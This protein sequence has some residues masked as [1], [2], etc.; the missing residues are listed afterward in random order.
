MICFG[1]VEE[2][3]LC[4]L[5]KNS[6]SQSPTN[7][8]NCSYQVKVTTI[9]KAVLCWMSSDCEGRWSTRNSLLCSNLFDMI[10]ALWHCSLSCWR[11]RWVHK[12]M[13]MVSL[14]APDGSVVWALALL[15]HARKTEVFVFFFLQNLFIQKNRV[16]FFLFSMQYT[17]LCRHSDM[18]WNSGKAAAAEPL[19][20]RKYPP[21]VGQILASFK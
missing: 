13:D 20:L 19:R 6:L 21:E 7:F 17:S 11:F 1:A 3:V 18:G 8:S 16:V 4:T 14:G 12:R 9:L 10:W 5:L 2:T 15:R